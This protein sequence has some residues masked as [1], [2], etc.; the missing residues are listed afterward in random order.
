MSRYQ[1]N[2][3]KFGEDLAADFFI[4]QGYRIL[5]RNYRTAVG[6]LDLVAETEELLIFAEVKTRTSRRFGSPAEA[7]DQKKQLHMR[8]TAEIWLAEHP[9][10]KEIRFDV[11]EVYAG[12]R[13]GDPY[14]EKIRHIPGIILEV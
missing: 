3:G 5:E 14:P 12:I 8:K 10:E 6:E 7:V 11:L 9:T 1:K 13:N 2:L 4:E